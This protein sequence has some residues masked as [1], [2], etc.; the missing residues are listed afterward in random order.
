[1]PDE[2]FIIYLQLA[3]NLS[4]FISHPRDMTERNVFVRTESRI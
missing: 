2:E 1:V 4:R 3:A